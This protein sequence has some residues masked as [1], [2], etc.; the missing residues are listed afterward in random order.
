MWKSGSGPW[1]EDET[2]PCASWRYEKWLFN[3]FPPFSS[4][5]WRMKSSC[6]LIKRSLNYC[7]VVTKEWLRHETHYPGAIKNGGAVIKCRAVGNGKRGGG[8]GTTHAPL[9]WWLCRASILSGSGSFIK[10]LSFLSLEVQCVA[11][12]FPII[13]QARLWQCVFSGMVLFDL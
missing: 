10:H 6:A 3:V 2:Q 8:T 11:H 1:L 5:S 12:E 13:F 7:D 9:P 4:A